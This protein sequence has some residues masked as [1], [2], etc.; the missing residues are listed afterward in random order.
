MKKYTIFAG[1]NG[2]GKTTLYQTN[3]SFKEIPRINMDEIVREF[4]SWKNQEDS[5]KAG[6]IAVY[7]IKNIFQKEHLFYKRQLCVEIV[8]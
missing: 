1:C 6:K 7:K 3:P 4:G 2:T 8:F 5:I